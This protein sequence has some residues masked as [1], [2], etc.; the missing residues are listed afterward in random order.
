[1]HLYKD[2]SKYSQLQEKIIEEL[3]LFSFRLFECLIP[4]TPL[5]DMKVNI[6]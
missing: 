2:D 5:R 3:R 4:N 1:M 6:Y